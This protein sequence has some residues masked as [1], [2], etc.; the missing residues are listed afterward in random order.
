[1]KFKVTV[2]KGEVTYV[3]EA[4]DRVEAKVLAE[5]CYEN[6]D[7]EVFDVEEITEDK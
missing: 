2:S 7:F 5:D 6:R 4:K 3:V 1:M